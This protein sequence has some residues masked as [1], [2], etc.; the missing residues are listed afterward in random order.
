MLE[1]FSNHLESSV[2]QTQLYED[3]KK[4]NIEDSLAIYIRAQNAGLIIRRQ[5][6][7]TTF[8][9][10]EVQAQ[11]EEVMSAPGKI[12]RHFPGPAVQVPN[13]VAEDDDFIKEVANILSRMNTEVFDKARPKSHK[14]GNEVDESR[15]S[16]NPNYF[17]Q[18]FFGFL[19]GMGAM[20]NP[21]RIVKRLA[22]EVLWQQASNPWRRSPI[23]L[24]IRVALQTSF[25]SVINYKHFMAYYHARILSQCCKHNSFPSD[26]LHAMRVKMAR[27][28]YKLKD[29]VP[30]FL[31]D[32]AKAAANGAQDLLQGRWDWIQ[33]AQAKSSD[34]DFSGVDSDSAIIHTLPHSRSYLERVFQGRTGHDDYS[35]FTPNHHPRLDNVIEF[36]RYADR[37]KGLSHAFKNDPHLALFDFEASVFGNLA[38]WTS[39][40]QDYSR[41]CATLSSCFQQY[42]NTATSYY[43][44]DIADHSIMI[45]TL[46]RIWMAIDEL[47]TRDHPLL[48]D[49]SPELPADLLNPLLLR[50]TQ[51]IEQ[52]RI[53][54]QYIDGRHTSAVSRN[55]SIFSDD[56]TEECFAVQFFEN[57][58]RHQ[59]IKLEIEKRAQEQRDEKMQ[60]LETQN[61]KYNRL[62]EEIQ[63]MSCSYVDSDGWTHDRWCERHLKIDERDCLRITPC[64]WPL[65]SD[66]LDAKL[67]VFEL[68]RPES[69]AIWRDITYTI[70]VDLGTRS[71]R[72]ECTRY[73]TLEEYDPL[74]EW[75]SS[76]SLTPRVT[77]ASITKS[78]MQSHYGNSRSLPTTESKVCLASGHQ[79]KLYD[80]TGE[81]WA[82]EPFPE[83]T[84]VKYGTLQLPPDSLYRHLEYALGKTSHNS[85]QVLAD[86]HDCPME[87]SLHEHIAFG[88]LRSGPRLQWMNIVRGLDEDLLSFISDEVWL[89]HTQAAWQI[90][91]LSDD[92]SREWHEDLGHSEF[93]FL[94]VS[95]CMRVLGRVKANWLQAKSVLTIVTLVNRLIASSPS[96]EVVQVACEFLQ[97]ARTV[98]LKWL[99]ELLVKLKDATL[100]EDVIDYQ[101]RVCEMAAICRGTYNI[102]P[103]H[104]S[105]L[106]SEPS[107]YAALIKASICLYDNQPP[108]LKDA[109]KSLQI[110]LCR[111][112]RFAHQ[113]TQYMLASIN[114]G[115]DILLNPLSKIWPG[116]R[117]GPLGWQIYSPPNGRWIKTVT[118]ACDETRAQEVHLNLITGQLLID[119]KPLGRLPRKYVEHPTYIRLFG[120]KIL[121]VVPAKSAGMEFATRGLVHGHE[122]S[123]ALEEDGQLIIQAGKDNI[124]Y[125]L[126]PHVKLSKD[127]S[128][129]FSEDYHH[130][131][132]IK[133]KTV[134]FRPVSS[135]WSANSHRWLLRF[136]NSR[137]TLEHSVDGSFVVDTHSALFQ[138]VAR[139]LVPLE[140]DRYLHVSRSVEG[141]VEVDLPRMKLSFFIN[142]D[143]EVEAR[144]FRNQVLDENQSA[145]TF[146][147]LKNQLVLRAKDTLAQSLPRSRSILIPDGAVVFTTQDHHVSVSIQ[148]DSR[149]S[150]DVHRYMVDEDLGYLATDAGLDSRL[151]KIYLHAL[152]NHCLPD[153]LTGRTGT[154]E[155]LHELS[156]ASTSSFEQLNLKQVKL[157]TAIGQLSP[158]RQYYPLHLQCMETTRW[159]D[160]PSLSQ[161]VA[162]S[163]AATQVLRRADML[164]LFH[165][166]EFKLA[167][168][169]TALET[170]DTLMK[171]V[172]R[173]TAVYYPSDTTGLNSQILGPVPLLDRVCPG[174]DSLAGEWE[175]AGQSASWASGLAYQ[176]WG[177]PVFKPYNLVFLAESWGTLHDTGK[178][179][180]L[181]YHSAWFSLSLESSW[182]TFYNLLRRATTAGN[183]YMLCACLASV[184]F[185]EAV[186]TDLIPV[187]V[188][189]ATNPEFRS[190]EPPSHTVFKFE[191]RYEPTRARVDG[192]ASKAK[193]SIQFTPA[194]ELT[195]NF[196]ETAHAFRSRRED[197]YHSNFPSHKS[198][199]V[200][201]LMNQWPRSDPQPSIQLYSVNSDHSRWFNVESC[202]E[203]TRQYFSSCIWNIKMR[204][205]LRELETSLAF[206]STSA[207]TDF[208]PI[209]QKPVTLST[210][211][212]AFDDPWN[213]LNVCSL[214]KS[215][216][217]PDPTDI[218]LFPEFSVPKR[219]KPSANTCRLRDLFAEF[220]QNRNALNRLYAS[221]LEISRGELETKPNVSFPQLFPPDTMRDLE[222]TRDRCKRNLATAFQQFDWILSPQSEVERIA[223]MSGVWPR[224][225]P[226]TILQRLSLRNRLQFDLLP[227]W[228]DEVIGYAQ[229]FLDYQKSQRL[230]AIADSKHTEEFYKE[231]DLASCESDS[232]LNDPEWLLVQIDGNFGARIVQRQVA[233]EMISPSFGSNT[234]LQ[235]NM[236]EGKSSVIVPIVASSLADSTRL[237]RV[238]VLK[239]L[240]RQMFDL[241][242][243][244]LSG[245]A[246]RRI[247]YLPFGRHISVDT[248]S[249]Q[250]LRNL[251]EECLR[252]GGIL[253]AQ[254]EHILSFK[255]MGIERLISTGDSSDDTVARALRNTQGWLETH[256]RDILDESDEI[257][258][259]RYQLVYTIGEQQPP[260]DHPNR[261]TTTQQLLRLAAMHVE[262]LQKECPT[263]AIHKNT[264][265]GRFP[266]LRIMPDCPEELQ[267]KLILDIVTDVQ[268]GRLLNLSCDRLPLSVR[269]NLIELFTNNK[270]SFSDYES[271]RHACDPA[272]WNGLLLLRG[273]LAS[274]ILVFALKHRHY[275]VDYG[276][277][278]NRSLL[279]VPYGAKDIPSL[280][281]EFGHPDVAIVLTCLSYYYHG[282]TPTQLS[283]CFELLFKLDNPSLEYEQWVIRNESTPEE[284][285]Q[286]NG[287]NIKDRQ[288][289]AG[290]LVENFA[291]NSATIDFFLSS[292][293]FPRGAKE[294]PTKLATSGWDLAEKRHHTTTGFSGTNDNRYILPTSISQTDPVKQLSTNALVLNY[295]LQPE[296]KFYICIRNEGGGSLTTN[297]FLTLLVAQTPKV[298]VL[299]DVGAQIL[300][301]QNEELVRRWLCLRPDV[302]AAVY[303]N[304][305]DELVVLP[306]KGSP[307]PFSTSP[308]A[309][310][311][312]K[313]IVYLDDGH[314]RGT[315]LKL[316]RDSRALVTL[317]PKVTKDRLLQG[318]MRMRKLGHGQSV[319]FAAP[320]EIDTQIRN[321]CPIPIDLDSPIDALDVLRWAMQETCKDL[322][323]HVSH[324]AQQGVD[325]ARRHKAEKEY[326]QTQ[327]I[328]AL[329]KAW[330][331][332][333]ARTL[334]EM[335]GVPSPEALQLKGSF[336]KRASLL[337]ELRNGLENLG[338]ETLED[339][340]MD[341]EQEREVAHEVER[342]QETQR[343]PKGEAKGHAIHPDVERFISTGDLQTAQSGI[344]PLFSPFY[345][346]HPEISNSWSRLLFASA[347]F[348]Q[349]VDGYSSNTLSE[350]MRPVNWIVSAGS[351]RVVLGPYE[352]NKLLP[353]IRKSSKVQLHVYAPRVSL[354]MR[355]FSGLDFY[356]IPTS[357]SAHSNPG[358][359][360]KT[361]LQ[362]DLFAGQLYLSDYEDY[363]SLCTSLGLFVPSDP[364]KN[365]RIEVDGDGFVKP[366]HRGELIRHH[367]EYTDCNF[368]ATPIP[369][370]K[371]LIGRRRKGMR[372]LLTHVGQI[373]HARNLAR[374]DFQHVSI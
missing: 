43:T 176:N 121:D 133:H 9:A 105:L 172:L 126:I 152:T 89:L 145:G 112:R 165:P 292:V 96:I 220:Q 53:I 100:E 348:L 357:L 354:S 215:R 99:D 361:Q 368:L 40:Q 265:G 239:P 297:G 369:A 125:E 254:P 158:K 319:M 207:G 373:L 352:V 318:C 137:T 342:Q 94:L 227:A 327:D 117:S 362:L 296:N 340:S 23:W 29:T 183:K 38:D 326:E 35:S 28:I 372:Y 287:V 350:Y 276:L 200:D 267:R 229:A 39:G 61:A 163:F 231:L 142:E 315:D 104:M 263:G 173:R 262:K 134:E 253:L 367:P 130:W 308:F 275:R 109:P 15:N 194:K 353:L 86:Q 358:G 285:K 150:V 339:P 129:F 118:A 197:Y 313:C 307:S 85:N 19:R 238:V 76:P 320:P 343:P 201:S 131:A 90:G 151:F 4:L 26:L 80:N 192:N 252:E 209:Y 188:A 49:Y 108:N 177:R 291:H 283:L 303:F 116:Y 57:S 213:A 268:N 211:C 64:E 233:Q 60:E 55:P 66:Q 370:L 198:Q 366:Q 46:M 199:F 282:L 154:E 270:L 33:S 160:L 203:S 205:H 195:R 36:T 329:Q 140:S 312:D 10:F 74:S 191:D 272:S 311:L 168:Y 298:Q 27:R 234:V 37:N 42:F 58:P 149:R 101:Y 128:F 14:G 93:G 22:D 144:N 241:L 314:T 120:Q 295:L 34:R 88:T 279:A 230:M 212:R 266:M 169:I 178:H 228:K 20:M 77:I 138:S 68:E 346:S 288:Q 71:P 136:D 106:L 246:N 78:M 334:E 185:G 111:D 204:D 243:N 214:M 323:H 83:V 81:A 210:T 122:V 107:N 164:Q 321:A 97:E 208:A 236:G 171:R 143:G 359:L 3:L 242:V 324:W 98:A 114:K 127:F 269:N 146:F 2:E 161:H 249:S 17:I 48:S 51:H 281:A 70:L 180:T 332:P 141:L 115:D 364:E 189:F 286:L 45:L 167:E 95:Q 148:F 184:A 365:M 255:L 240:W 67:V 73:A 218:T 301:L 217:N 222:Q 250:T 290:P 155:A 135:P 257:L 280:R 162:F 336:M 278:L 335:Y 31:V 12:V 59:E 6:A 179:R 25:D 248:S 54:Q 202:L 223:F 316:P 305:R 193:H 300:D 302:K 347:D 245:L 304:D 75:L 175:E 341:E 7:H 32:A 284:L 274:G 244:R 30:Q 219:T 338:V 102:E 181:S 21:P 166:L 322:Q 371:E 113:I 235:L 157:L 232:G 258:H 259:V 289:F 363:V 309:Q 56:A 256:T 103:S 264:E 110:V 345:A 123:F 225:T 273:L 159:V 147:G 47:T 50:T 349:T 317:G 224:I 355:S 226:R 330:A 156:Q 82:T 251:Y 92:G 344:I 13:S 119:G 41:A 237:V 16:I 277:D 374:E 356:S 337:P 310:Q 44:A 182:I 247:Y 170:D 1:R 5:V 87:L 351:L 153:P 187:F 325:Y 91:K 62:S 52:A 206:R 333:E 196:G 124:L 261:W 139:W 65:P 69:F 216:P 221:D 328:S 84:F 331:A 306:Q 360:S 63:G 72:S 186:P 271:L 11:T 132:D 293:V 79:F 174:R 260:D 18:F 299:L 24:V 294:F 8:E 190:L